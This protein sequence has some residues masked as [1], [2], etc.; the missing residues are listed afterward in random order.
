M[1]KAVAEGRVGRRRG[2]N[3]STDRSGPSQGHESEP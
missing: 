3:C 1:Q 2:R